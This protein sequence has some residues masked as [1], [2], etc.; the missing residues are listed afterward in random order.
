[1][2]RQMRRDIPRMVY[3]FVQST[4]SSISHGVFKKMKQK[5]EKTNKNSYAMRI[6]CTYSFPSTPSACSS[7]FLHSFWTFLLDSNSLILWNR[8]V[9]YYTQKSP[10]ILCS[11]SSK[12]LYNFKP[13]FV[14]THFNVV[15][16]LD[17]ELQGGLSLLDCNNNFVYFSRLTHST[18]VMPPRTFNFTS[19]REEIRKG[20][21]KNE[22]F[23]YK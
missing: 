6:F 22:M 4:L 12:Q 14:N 23:V 21:K 7:V 1:M 18:L 20:S 5:K 3:P 17:V 9:H 10:H 16:P 11:G 19:Y 13:D 8:E 15:L 2:G